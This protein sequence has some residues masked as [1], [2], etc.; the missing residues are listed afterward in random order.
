LKRL[1]TS[2]EEI[3]ETP[4]KLDEVFAAAAGDRLPTEKRIGM[5]DMLFRLGVIAA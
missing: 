2:P 4:K 3:I 1:G 5:K